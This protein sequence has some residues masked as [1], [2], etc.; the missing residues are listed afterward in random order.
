MEGFNG[1]LDSSSLEAKEGGGWVSESESESS[2]VW[3]AV[4]NVG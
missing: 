3:E 4:R 1:S 2:E